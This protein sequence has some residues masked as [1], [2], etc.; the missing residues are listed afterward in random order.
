MITLGKIF[1]FPI[2]LRYGKLF[3]LSLPESVSLF[4]RIKPFIK[5]F[6]RIT[7]IFC[8]TWLDYWAL[9]MRSV[10]KYNMIIMIQPS[11]KKNIL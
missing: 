5:L 11:Q 1:F 8:I 3:K 6:L 10:A 9:E 2:L 4:V 7:K